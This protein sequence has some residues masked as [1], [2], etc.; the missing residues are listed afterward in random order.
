MELYIAN[1]FS[2]STVGCIFHCDTAAVLPIP[3]VQT[4]DASSPLDRV[5]SALRGQEV[6]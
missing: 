1:L 2:I 6:F 5:V 3:D 4:L